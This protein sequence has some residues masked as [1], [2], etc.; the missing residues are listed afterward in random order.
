LIGIKLRW[1]FGLLGDALQTLKAGL[2]ETIDHPGEKA[3]AQT[4]AYGIFSGTG[5]ACGSGA[6]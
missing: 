4:K 5:G 1:T 6:S 3:F 2:P